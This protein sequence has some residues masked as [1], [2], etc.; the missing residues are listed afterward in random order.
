MVGHFVVCGMG[1]VGY[2]VTS[3]LLDLGEKVSVITLPTRS[4]WVRTVEARGVRVLV[5]DARDDA[6]IAEAGID[7]ARA[8]IAA[9]DQDA[10]NVEL[11]LDAAQ[12]RPELPVVI[13]L[14]DRQ[15]AL[16]IEAR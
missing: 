13:R 4:D 3:L 15:L 8:L 11:A 2:R 12:R 5:G 9:T 1:Q 7:E 10:V 6:L 14:F 16:Q